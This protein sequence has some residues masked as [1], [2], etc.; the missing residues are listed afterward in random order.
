VTGGTEVPDGIAYQNKD[1]LFK[2]LSQHYENKSFEVFGVNLPK[3]KKVLP[4]NLPDV[5]AKELRPDNIFLLEDGRILIVDYE[6][7][8]RAENFIKYLEYIPVVLKE[9]FNLEKKVYNVVMLVIYTGDI[10]DAP[11]SFVTDSLKLNIMQ[12]F[13]SRFDTDA[14]YSDLKRKIENKEKLTD[15]DVMRF[16]ILPLTEKTAKKKQALI[17]N[18]IGLA[19]ELTDEKQQ[20]FIIAGILVAADKFIDKDYSKMMKGWISMTKISRLYEEEKIEY[21]NEVAGKTANNVFY[22][23][24]KEML[25]DNEDVVK[26]MKYSKLP[27]DEIIKIQGELG[28]ASGQ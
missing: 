11:D 2:V 24:A 23:L 10:D 13:L 3:I 17:E 7:K 21:G 12:V 9:Y 19:Q 6:S 5:S 28:L 4:T 27:K 16:I 22:S 8:V 26:I 15:E 20:L 14:L 25:M 1:V 18:T